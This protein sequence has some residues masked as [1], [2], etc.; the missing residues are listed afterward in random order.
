MFL[1]GGKDKSV[2]VIL[3]KKE[4]REKRKR[5]RKMIETSAKNLRKR[6]GT[7]YMRRYGALAASSLAAKVPGTRH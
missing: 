6:P 5:K 4:K 3:K 2:Q 1:Q 7:K